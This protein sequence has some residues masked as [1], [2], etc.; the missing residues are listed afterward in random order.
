MRRTRA[1]SLLEIVIAMAI[2]TIALLSTFSILATSQRLQRVSSERSRAHAVVQ[3]KIAEL[4]A[5]LH[6][7]AWT[8]NNEQ[9]EQML[10]LLDSIGTVDSGTGLINVT[11]NDVDILTTVSHNNDRITLKGTL[12]VRAYLQEDKAQTQLGLTDIDLDG[13]GTTNTSSVKVPDSPGDKS[14]LV[15][16]VRVTLTWRPTDWKP[17]DA[18]R[19]VELGAIIY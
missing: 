8:S 9:R 17:G 12:S 11:Y 10:A 18:D 13:D 1:F 4:R 15:L 5:K 3:G 16:P 14:L 19:K 7:V 6:E 2:I